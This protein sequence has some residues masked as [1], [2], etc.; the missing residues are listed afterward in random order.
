M[1]EHNAGRSGGLARATLAEMREAI[2]IPE[3]VTP[4]GLRVRA[5]I[6]RKST[7]D[8]SCARHLELAAD[9]IT[10]L[11]AKKKGDDPNLEADTYATATEQTTRGG[12]AHPATR[13]ES[14]WLSCHP[15]RKCLRSWHSLAASIRY[16]RGHRKMMRQPSD[17]PRVAKSV[18]QLYDTDTKYKAGASF[19]S[20]PTPANH[21]GRLSRS[22]RT[23][24]SSTEPTTSPIK[25]ATPARRIFST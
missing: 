17:D 23:C 16:I 7:G 18:K 11:K 22:P 8:E 4:K 3:H 12:K 1:G 5:D 19:A 20:R 15:V 10:R 24:R 9:E 2:P 6:V 13:Q 21:S 14:A 25:A